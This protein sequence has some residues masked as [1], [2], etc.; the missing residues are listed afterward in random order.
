MKRSHLALIVAIAA[1]IGGMTLAGDDAAAKSKVKATPL[2]VLEV[3]EKEENRHEDQPRLAFGKPVRVT[4]QE[5]PQV[6]GFDVRDWKGDGQP[7]IFG[8]CG[9]L[10]IFEMCHTKASGKERRVDH[11]LIFPPNL[12]EVISTRS[13]RQGIVEA[14]WTCVVDWFNGGKFDVLVSQKT[15][16]LLRNRGDNKSPLFIDS[17]DLEGTEAFKKLV[18]DPAPAD[19][20]ML[21]AVVGDWDGDGK[22]DLLIARQTENRMGR[23]GALFFCKNVGKDEAPRF[24]DPQE[25]KFPDGK[26]VS[27]E[28]PSLADFDGSGKLALLFTS[29][30]CALRKR[31][32]TWVSDPR[33]LLCRRGEDPLRLEEPVT[34]TT[35]SGKVIPGGIQAQWADWEGKGRRDLLV[36]DTSPG[37]IRWY[38]NV[39]AERKP[40]VFAEGEE[41]RGKDLG[42]VNHGEPWLVDLAGTG[43]PD[44]VISGRFDTNCFGTDLRVRWHPVLKR[45]QESLAAGEGQFI[46]V[47]TEQGFVKSWTDREGAQCDTP[48]FWG[49]LA[50][51]KP[52][53][54]L[55]PRSQDKLLIFEVLPEKAGGFAF[56]KPIEVPL[57][58]LKGLEAA[59]FAYEDYDGDGQKDLWVYVNQ[60]EKPGKIW[61]YP[62]QGTTKAP[63]FGDAV[64]ISL[65]GKADLRATMPT[66]RLFQLNGHPALMIA[67]VAARSHF[68][69]KL[70]VYRSKGE[71]PLHFDTGPEEITVTLTE[72]L[73]VP[74][75]GN[76]DLKRL[77]QL[78]KEHGGP[79]DSRPRDNPWLRSFWVG[80]SHGD[81]LPD[82][83]LMLGYHWDQGTH[84]VR[85]E[86]WY[87][88]SV[89]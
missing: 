80:D 82:L 59:P 53:L 44:L 73:P 51:K 69:G 47:G 4:G 19:G 35:K 86:T 16:L 81:G 76:Y 68:S 17:V 14:Y 88:P 43:R 63:K 54:C 60:W 57:G 25:I 41:I 39:A 77:D 45:S 10:Q 48:T 71:K 85:S 70:L 5:L 6:A 64:S 18:N 83:L 46:R 23:R 2:S 15:V 9:G 50:E 40:P 29:V 65:G 31:E 22:K 87:Y 33:V 84:M 79:W 74:N 11:G 56:A 8:T 28:G 32:V 55:I 20:T 58:G 24:A 34:L 75:F 1:G 67:P 38:R 12:T 7:D 49:E 3:V 66:P 61:V 37:R 21:Q 30:N 89:K 27:L 72:S 26:S 78:L 62:N 36:L 42:R 13:N 52:A